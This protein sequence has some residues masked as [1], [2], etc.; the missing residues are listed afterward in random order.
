KGSIEERA[1]QKEITIINE[2]SVVRE[3]YADEKMITSVLRNLLSNAVK[4]TNK[5]GKIIVK[6]KEIEEGLVE[7]SI[8]DTGVG[9]PADNIGKLFCLS[10][11]LGNIGTDNEPSAGLGLVLC[12][13]FVEKHGGKI[14]VESRENIGSTFYFTIPSIDKISKVA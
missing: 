3:I 10:E 13:D 14:W 9:I 11:K 6:A 2:N 1:L 12:K 5:G 8:T 4:F 7:I